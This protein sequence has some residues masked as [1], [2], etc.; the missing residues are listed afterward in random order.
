MPGLQSQTVELA[1]AD[2]VGVDAAGVVEL[3]VVEPAVVGEVALALGVEPEQAHSP[4]D[5][6]S[7]PPTTPRIRLD[8]IPVE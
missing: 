8:R 3:V 4:N 2:V 7:I 5:R 6:P 1:V